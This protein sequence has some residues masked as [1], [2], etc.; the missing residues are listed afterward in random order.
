MLS[1]HPFSITDICNQRHVL[2][3]YSVLEDPANG[4]MWHSTWHTTI[5]WIVT[6]LFFD[7]VFDTVNSDQIQVLNIIYSGGANQ[8][9]WTIKDDL[10]IF[11]LLDTF[12]CRVYT[13][14]RG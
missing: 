6:L 14:V 2:F 10:V 13:Y 3:H 1:V 12:D 8:M 5:T 11:T 7:C 9:N 4:S